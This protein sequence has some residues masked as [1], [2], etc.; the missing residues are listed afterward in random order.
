LGRRALTAELRRKGVADDTVAAAVAEVSAD[1]EA[2]AARALAERRL[3]TMTGLTRDTQLRRLVGML[4]RKGFSQGLAV[5]AA[6]DALAAQ[7]SYER[8]A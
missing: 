2:A 3:R 6:Q 1:D 8:G 4:A 7:A 5:R